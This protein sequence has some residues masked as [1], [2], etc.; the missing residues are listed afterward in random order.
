MRFHKKSGVLMSV[1]AWIGFIVLLS[2]ASVESGDVNTVDATGRLAVLVYH[3]IEEPVTSDVSCTPKAFESQME[4]LQKSGF[5]PLDLE[6][7][8]AFLAGALPNVRNPVLITFDDGYES[9]YVH[10][11]PVAR[12]LRIPMTVFMITARAG[13]KPQFTRY[14][15]VSQIREMSDSG[16]F[17]FGS[18]TDD[19]HVDLLLIRSSF[20]RKPNPVLELLREDLLASRRKL[21][22]IVGHPV[23]ALAWPY[24]KHDADTRRIARECGFTLQFTSRAGYNEPESDPYEIKRIPV[25][26]R[27]S[28]ASMLKKT[29]G[30]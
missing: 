15:S 29:G 10:A 4:A 11:L 24:G 27:D 21:E 19:L 28:V 30:R 5:T 23:F 13:L 20:A 7:A 3:H 25:T 9:L 6:G 8:R 17:S 12:R 16:Y 22:A 18:H 14:L 2:S 1:F 26:S